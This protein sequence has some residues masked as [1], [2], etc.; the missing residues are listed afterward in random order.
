MLLR[1]IVSN[2]KSIG[3]PVEFS[4]LSTESSIDDRFIKTIKTRAGDW[5]VLSRAGFFGPNASGKTSFI[6]SLEFARN[7]IVEGQKSGKG[8]GVN[9]FKG[10][11]QD[12]KNIS[13]FQFMFY[14]NSE[15]YEYGFSLDRYQIYEEWLMVLTEKDFAPLFTRVTDSNGQTQIDIESKFA[16]KDSKDRILAEALK[17]GIQENQKNQLFLYKLHDNGIK[18]AEQ[19][20]KWFK[21]LQ[22]IFPKTKIQ[23]LP[24]RIQANTDFKTFIAE[25]LKKLDTGVSNISV[26]SDDIDFQDLAE[27]LDLPKE[28]M[29]EIEE[30]KN[31]I[32]NLNGK[33]FIFSEDKRKRTVFVQIKFEHRLNGETVKFNIDE[34]SDGTQRLL[35]LLPILFA[36]NGKSTFIYFI[37]EIDRSL[38]TKLSQYLLNKFIDNCKETYNQIIFTAHD[39]NLIDFGNFNNNEIWFIEKNRLGESILKPLSDFKMEEGQDVLKAYLSGR[40]GAVPMIRGER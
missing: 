5:K 27:K 24:L 22:A 26:V 39:V 6:E 38:H 25:N 28:I 13:T 16:R 35:D 20:V 18:K 40:F 36:M 3:C 37:D 2:F 23:G 10:T 17:E 1:Y 15:V 21:G 7:F 4:M 34:E 30:I 8:T 9:Q 29:E 14:L 19:I 32:I 11:F 33:Y 12:N 31:G